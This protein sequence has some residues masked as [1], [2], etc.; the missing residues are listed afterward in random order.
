MDSNNGFIY[1][2]LHEYYKNDKICKLGK[3]KNIINRD[4]DYATGEYK[5]GYFELV[6][7]IL[8][9]QIF[10]DTFVEK[11]LQRYF[12]NYHT[13]INGG[14]E[15]Y[16]NEIME[17]IVPFLSNTTIKF[18]VLSKEEINNLI[19][20][21]RIKKL[22]DVLKNFFHNR[23]FDTKENKLRNKLQEIY[24]YEINDKLNINRRTFISGPTGFGKT[25]LYYK[26]ILRKKLNRTLFLTP[27]L[28]LNEQIVED[29]YSS[30]F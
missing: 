29:K 13:K 9:N 22:K 18:K 3:T 23:Q 27:R 2:R 19:R 14:S 26:I 12:K 11:L 8:N 30:D 15:F 21:E 20:Q 16:Y 6:V 24:V 5:R 4:D 17:E 28:A 25:H 7:E 1:V 10:N